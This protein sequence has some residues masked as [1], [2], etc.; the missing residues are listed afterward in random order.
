MGQLNST[1]IHSTSY[2]KTS[3]NTKNKFTALRLLEMAFSAWSII[4][5]I[6]IATVTAAY[7]LENEKC[8]LE[9]KPVECPKSGNLKNVAEMMHRLLETSVMQQDPT[10]ETD[11]ESECTFQGKPI[12]CP[13]SDDSENAEAMQAISQ[14]SRHSTPS[15]QFGS[16]FQIC[17]SYYC[18]YI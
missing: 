9:G 5:A 2:N 12:N 7:P 13:K 6:F 3:P 18:K 11:S 14:C 4:L 15:G 16:N 10:D 17:P 1:I 8:S